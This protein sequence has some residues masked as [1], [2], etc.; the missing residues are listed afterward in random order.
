[1]QTA[2]V[3]HPRRLADFLR[4][5]RSA[6]LDRWEAAVR[7]LRPAKDL[8]RP[9]LLNHIPQF[10][11]EL[12]DF[13][14]DLRE[15]RPAAP[16]E[17][18]PRLHA[19][20]RL[21]M[22]YDLA[23]VVEEYSLLR[24]CILEMAAEEHTPAVRSNELPRLHRAIDL[25]IALSVQR[26]EQA[27]AEL[28]SKLDA[29]LARER[30]RADETLADAQRRAAELEAVIE[31]IPDAVYIGDETGMKRINQ[32]ALDQLGL[33][34]REKLNRNLGTLVDEMQVRDAATGESMPLEEQVFTRALA[35]ETAVKDVILKNR[36]SGEDI[37]VRSAAAPICLGDKLVGAVA[38]NTDIT[39]R[40]KQERELRE[41]LEISERLGGVLAH[42]LRNPLGVISTSATLLQRE[43]LEVR[44]ARIV[45]RISRS[46]ERIERMIHDL[47]DYTRAQRGGTLPAS[48]RPTDLADTCR[49]V[50]EESE[51]LFP[52]S[53]VELNV[54]GS[55]RGEWDP[56]RAYQAVSNLV[57]NAIRYGAA[58]QPVRIDVR[59]SDREVIVSVH[60][61]GPAIPAAALG[62]IFEP[63]Q[64]GPAPATSRSGGLGLGLYIVRQIALAHGGSVEVTSDD[65][66][67]TTFCMRWPRK[68]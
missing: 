37:V 18:I 59:G 48:P 25:A 33:E 64:R 15:H 7:Q 3:S 12:E 67:G 56:D 2:A 45:G 63:F 23:D 54:E 32:R 36:K 22:G 30:N 29:E 38:I 27:A 51:L 41:A 58:N 17:D 13:V 26:F 20:E 24:S 40:N 55:A 8:R 57:V 49:L 52:G 47:L 53:K 10:L 5:R 66:V 46:A 43:A 39:E 42:D 44:H 65:T 16:P 61:L 4:E 28:R 19:V 9:A 34:S 14:G 35:G 50:A 60:N 1:M 31:S 62:A 6:I 21:E 68:R 11:E